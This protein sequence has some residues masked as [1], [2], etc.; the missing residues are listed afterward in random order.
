MPRA[1]PLTLG[2][3]RCFVQGTRPLGQLG[4]DVNTSGK[5]I[6]APYSVVKSAFLNPY[7]WAVTEMFG[8]IGCTAVVL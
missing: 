8:Y 4:C 3:R 7:R 1:E 6:L 2:A 5:K